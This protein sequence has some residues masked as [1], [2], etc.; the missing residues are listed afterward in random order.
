MSPPST[1]KFK[2]PRAKHD[3]AGRTCSIAAVGSYVPKRVLTNA[4]L[5]KIV[6]TS[7]EWIV[8]RTGIKE[9]RIAEPNEYTSD[10]AAAAA[11]LAMQRA[12]VTADQ[13]DLIIVATVTPDLVF[14]STACLVQEKLGA[15]RAAE[16]H[17]FEERIRGHL[18]AGQRGAARERAEGR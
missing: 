5:E 6:D 10:M 13:I 9:R 17:C 4:D 16:G 8:S 15:H 11:L 1:T 3:F 2:N 7:D 14:P 18:G 12:E